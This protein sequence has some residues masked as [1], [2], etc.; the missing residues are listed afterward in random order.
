MG[1]LG[2]IGG[3][4]DVERTRLLRIDALFP[5]GVSSTDNSSSAVLPGMVKGKMRPPPLKKDALHEP[6][7]GLPLGMLYVAANVELDEDERE[8]GVALLAEEAIEDGVPVQV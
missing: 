1:L 2:G 3:E 7:L 8:A 5:F 4:E 6:D